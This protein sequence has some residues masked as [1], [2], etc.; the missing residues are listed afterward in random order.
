[1]ETDILEYE[2]DS[3]KGHCVVSVCTLLWVHFRR[4]SLHCTV[5]RKVYVV[6]QGCI[7]V[8]GFQMDEIL[9]ILMEIRQKIASQTLILL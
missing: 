5:V 4:K 6:S 2:S 8:T 3:A 1:M 7:E 9:T